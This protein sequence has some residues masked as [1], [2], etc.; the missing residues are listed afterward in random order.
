MLA[1][2]SRPLPLGIRFVAKCLDPGLQSDCR[3]VLLGMLVAPRGLVSAHLVCIAQ[4]H[5]KR[6]VQ[7]D[8]KRAGLGRLVVRS[9]SDEG[10]A[11]QKSV[12]SGCVQSLHVRLHAS[13]DQNAT[14]CI[15]CGE[16]LDCSVGPLKKQNKAKLLCLT[17]SSQSRFLRQSCMRMRL[18]W[19]SS[20]S[21]GPLPAL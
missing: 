11:A 1:N 21:Q 4:S 13:E 19:L 20:R 14:V 2:L 15:C 9:M 6:I 10:K 12:E 7:Y 5:A 16:H 8:H 18:H 17:R 3:T